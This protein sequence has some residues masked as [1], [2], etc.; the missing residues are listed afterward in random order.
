MRATLRITWLLLSTSFLFHIISAG[1]NAGVTSATNNPTTKPVVTNPATTQKTVPATTAKVNTDLNAKSTLAPATA[2]TTKPAQATTVTAAATTI[3]PATTVTATPKPT[4]K[5]TPAQPPAPA[6][7]DNQSPTSATRTTAAMTPQSK[8]HP[9]TVNPTAVTTDSSSSGAV[10]TTNASVIQKIKPSDP[11]VTVAL[12]GTG[13][14]ATQRGGPGDV[15]MTPIAK[16]STDAPTPVQQSTSHTT[17]MVKTSPRDSKGGTEKTTVTMTN[18]QPTA[19]KDPVPD[20][21]T[22]TTNSPSTKVVP[23]VGGTSRTGAGTTAPLMPTIPATTMAAQPKTFQYSLNTGHEKDEEKE[24]VEVCRRLMLDMLDGNC[25]LTWRHHKGKVQFD[26]VVI[27]G[28]VKTSLATQIYE[29][30]NKKPTDNKTLIAILASC[31]ALLIMIVILAVCASHHRKPYNENQQHLT[32]ELHTVENGY[33]D[34][35]T[36]EVMEVQPEMQEKKMAPNGEFN[37]SWIVPMDNLL[38]E[39]MPDEEDTH[40]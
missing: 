24:L 40:L 31:G 30:I 36:L 33:H 13:L 28:K 4:E 5:Q 29:E 11:S 15:T 22:G 20:G 37:D 34:N 10:V 14:P 21:N 16:I 12:Q 19:S 25:T 9:V 7:T 1:D 38:K 27:N 23:P 6:V 8:T 32:E 39:D 2:E 17:I 3:M 18:Q 26:C 35:P